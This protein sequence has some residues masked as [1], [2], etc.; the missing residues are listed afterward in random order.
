[1]KV[2]FRTD[3]SL[4]IGTGHVIRCLTLADALREQGVQ[5]RFV[6]R[7]H[8]GHLIDLIRFRGYEVNNLPKSELSPS[9][10][11]DIKHANW[12]GVDWKI[13]AAQMCQVLGDI[14][15]D[16][17]VVD[18]YALDQRWELAVSKSCKRMMVIDDLAD[19]MHFCDLLLDQNYEE[20]KRYFRLVSKKTKSL[21]G[22][23]YALIHPIYATYRDK[24]VHKSVI[25]KN[26][27]IYFGGS[28][29]KDLTGATVSA[30]SS[31][32]LKHLMLDIVVGSNYT[33]FDSLEAAVSARG[34]ATIHQNRPHLADLM[35][36]ADIAIGAGGVSNW[37]RMCMGL[38][39]LVVVTAD[40]Q[41]LICE[42]L[43]SKGFIRLLGKSEDVKPNMIGS[44]VLNEIASPRL[45]NNVLSGMQICDGLGADRVVQNLLEI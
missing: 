9:F 36:A 31:P 33:F 39:S 21:L 26:I 18:H 37:E 10:E 24:K 41:N 8:Q 25:I 22:P 13:D 16:W 42:H 30:L 12:L 11:P 40:N 6:C 38:P 3:A 34:N 43:N 4:Q 7:E 32:N 23:S 19:R 2:A 20:R 14:F 45:F 28:D 17:V 15:F 27:F 5:C 1:M 44:A 29:E 35:F